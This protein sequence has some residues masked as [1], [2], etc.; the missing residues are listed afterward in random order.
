MTTGTN[1]LGYA[2]DLVSTILRRGGR[3]ARVEFG[4]V[5]ARTK[6]GFYARLVRPDYATLDPVVV[7]GSAQ[8]PTVFRAL[9]Q[10]DFETAGLPE[11]PP[12]ER[13]VTTETE[14]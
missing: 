8:A 6:D 10:L 7:L 14:E 4:A 3:R 11:P 5:G 1:Y 12:G 13:L 9:K 2:A